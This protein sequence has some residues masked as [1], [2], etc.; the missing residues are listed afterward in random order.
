M[1][2][3]LRDHSVPEASRFAAARTR[4]RAVPADSESRRVAVSDP[5]RSVEGR[6]RPA[7][8]F[9]SNPPDAANSG[10]SRNFACPFGWL[11]VSEYFTSDRLSG[12]GSARAYL[13]RRGQLGAQSL[14]GRE[15][16]RRAFCLL[17]LMGWAG[18]S[19]MQ[20][21]G[22]VTHP[23]WGNRDSGAVGR[24]VTRIL[25]NVRKANLPPPLLWLQRSSSM[26]AQQP[27]SNI[28]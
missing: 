16:D 20:F 6:E 4:V 10:C 5:G 11:A 21:S 17:Q 15:V 24:E 23:G 2:P 22:L 1:R 8:R 18:L 19:R 3:S 9:R 26:A 12:G 27:Q 14:F 7:A 25:K 13:F 28:S